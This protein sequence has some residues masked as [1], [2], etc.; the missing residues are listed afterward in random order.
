MK[1]FGYMERILLVF[2]VT[3]ACLTCRSDVTR[4][5]PIFEQ[6][7]AGR[8]VFRLCIC[9]SLV[10]CRM[11]FIVLRPVREILEGRHSNVVRSSSV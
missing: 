1:R 7:G 10:G 6:M 3:L 5:V 9:P 11:D 4:K 2:Q 8:Q